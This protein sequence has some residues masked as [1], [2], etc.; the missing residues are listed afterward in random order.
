MFVEMSTNVRRKIQ[1]HLYLF[2][3]TIGLVTEPAK[4]FYKNERNELRFL[5][6]CFVFTN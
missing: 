5:E 4:L 3:N 2:L 6:Y 1:I